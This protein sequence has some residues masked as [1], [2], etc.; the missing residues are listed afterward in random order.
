MSVSMHLGGSYLLR[1]S[2]GVLTWERP[3]A[4]CIEGVLAT[5]IEVLER[6]STGRG[7]TSLLRGPHPEGPGECLLPGV[8]T[9]RAARSWLCSFRACLLPALG[10]L[11]EHVGL[12]YVHSSVLASVP[13]LRG[14]S[15]MS[16]RGGRPGS[17]A[18]RGR[19][20]GGGE[21]PLSWEQG[22]VGLMGLPCCQGAGRPLQL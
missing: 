13:L 2:R 11:R 3:W 21:G 8:G 22:A 15:V 7:R 9:L 14:D 6:A 17:S 18:R 19:V 12:R 1:L 16:L 4:G 5:D 10:L 20:T